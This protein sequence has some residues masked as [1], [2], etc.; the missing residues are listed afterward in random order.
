MF[1]DYTWGCYTT[2][3][4]FF[5]YSGKYLGTQMLIFKVLCNLD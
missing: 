2:H 4:L 3:M 1:G 5:V